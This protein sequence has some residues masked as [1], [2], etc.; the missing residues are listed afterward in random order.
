[1]NTSNKMESMLVA[2][3]ALYMLASILATLSV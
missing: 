1:M 2:T 3:I